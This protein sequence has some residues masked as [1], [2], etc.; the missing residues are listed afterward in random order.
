MVIPSI[1]QQQERHQDGYRNEELASTERVSS[2]ILDGNNSTKLP[3]P[4]LTH[5]TF[6]SRRDEGQRFNN[7]LRRSST[8]TAGFLLPPPQELLGRRLV[9]YSP[10]LLQ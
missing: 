10:D 7:Q 6:D 1:N 8:T 3:S 9:S 4:V 5:T 2:Y